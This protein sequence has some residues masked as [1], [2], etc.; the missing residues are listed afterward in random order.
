MQANGYSKRRVKVLWDTLMPFADYAF[1]KAHIAGYGVLSYWTAYL[2]ANYPAEYMAALLTSVGDSKDKLGMYLSECRRMG[3]KV[4]AARRQRVARATSPP[5]RSEDGSATSASASAPC[6]T[7][8]SASSSRS[9]PRARRRG[10]S[11][12]S[13]TSCARCRSRSRTSAP[14]SRSS[15]RARSTRS[16]RPAA[17]SSRSTRTPSR[18]AVQRSSATRRTARS[19]STS[20]ASGTSPSTPSSHVP[21]RP[22]WAKRDK[23]AF[24]REML[25]L[26]VSDHP[27]AGL[28]MQLAKHATH[29]DHRAARRRG[30]RPTARHVTVAGLVTSVQHRTARNSRQPVRHRAGRGLRRRDHRHVPR[31]DLPGVLARPRERLDRRRAGPREHARRRHEPARR[32]ACSCPTPGRASAPGPLVISVAEHRATTDVVSALNDVL[33]RH[34]GDNEVRLRLVAR[35]QRADVRDP[36]PVAVTA[37]LYGELKRLLGPNCVCVVER[38]ISPKP[39]RPASGSR[40][41]GRAARSS[42]SPSAPSSIC[43]TID[44]VVDD[45]VAPDDPAQHPGRHAVEDGQTE[46]ARR[47]VVAGEAL[48]VIAGHDLGEVRGCARPGCGSARDRSAHRRPGARDPRHV[49]GRERRDGGER[50]ERGRGE[51]DR[52]PVRV[53]AR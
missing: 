42:C 16:A 17:R 13:T 8:A 48:V 5:C 19:G 3:I 41:R 29:H 9:G 50:G 12:R 53:R 2:K 24:E 39:G 40:A 49:E 6:A 1:N 7:S 36:Y 25:G 18:R 4:L 27:L 44:R 22:E 45:R 43:T 38:G 37:D 14:S 30:R 32:A 46:R 21:E 28:E 10:A 26:Y 35:R 23:L 52:A 15:R 20:T 51:A 34:A 31:Q 11:R 47:P 33:I